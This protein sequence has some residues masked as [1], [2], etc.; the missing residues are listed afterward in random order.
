MVSGGG[1]YEA[2]QLRLDI[3]AY[4]CQV[5]PACPALR[6]LE[7]PRFGAWLR[8]AARASIALRNAG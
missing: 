6:S 4:N 1:R 5:C 8:A 2:I 3:R 7:L